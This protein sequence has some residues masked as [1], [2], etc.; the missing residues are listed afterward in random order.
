M[1]TRLSSIAVARAAALSLD[2]S[3]FVATDFNAPSS[4]A[5]SSPDSQASIL[6]IIFTPA[7][8]VPCGLAVRNHRLEEKMILFLD[9]RH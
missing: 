2:S 7:R 4:N 3:A 5:D 8:I 9:E 6:D 1:F